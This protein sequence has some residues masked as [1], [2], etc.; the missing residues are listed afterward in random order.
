MYVFYQKTF[1]LH[2]I[3]FKIGHWMYG[4]TYLFKNENFRKIY[5]F[6]KY[7]PKEYKGL[8]SS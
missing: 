1:K 3:D 6:V 7:R 8:H 5:S 4:Y 2:Y